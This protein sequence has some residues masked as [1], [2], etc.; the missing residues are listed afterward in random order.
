MS[1]GGDVDSALYITAH[2]AN[3]PVGQICGACC[4]TG[5]EIVCVCV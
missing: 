5:C 1:L 4:T 3:V 2:P